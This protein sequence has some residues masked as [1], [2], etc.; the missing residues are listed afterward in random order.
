MLAV[1][2]RKLIFQKLQE[3]KR[4]VV[5][6][7]SREFGVSEE[8]IRR[9]LDRLASEGTVVKSYGGAVLNESDKIDMPFNVRK[10]FNV[11]GKQRIAALVA[12]MVDDGDHI[13]LDASTTAVFVAKALRRKQRL[14]VVTNS[15]EIL[16][17]LSDVPGWNLISV[18][19]SLKEGYLALV[20]PRT[21]E[22]LRRYRVEK[23]ILSCKGI[24]P[25]CGMLDG[26]EDFS[27]A[28]YEMLRAARKRILAVDKTKFGRAAFCKIAD[29]SSVDVVVTDEQPAAEWLERFEQLGV[30]CVWPGS[31]LAEL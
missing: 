28:K 18:G 21:T 10:K 2:R 12:G 25:V 19:G 26:N 15:V 20:G 7:L 24:D 30:K 3:E 17:E 23:A 1:E 6:D 14:T 29:L 9:D 8:T 4:V 31:A 27:Q 22:N 16:V 11:G 13:T 5:G